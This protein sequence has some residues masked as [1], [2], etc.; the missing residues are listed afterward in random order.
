MDAHTRRCRIGGLLIALAAIGTAFASILLPSPVMKYTWIFPILLGFFAWSR[1]RRGKRLG[2]AA[3]A[4][5]LVL[6]WVQLDLAMR[7]GISAKYQGSADA[8]R[9]AIAGSLW[10]GALLWLIATVR[11]APV[12]LVID[13]NPLLRKRARLASTMAYLLALG[14]LVAAVAAGLAVPD[15]LARKSEFLL[16]VGGAGVFIAGLVWVAGLLREGRCA[17]DAAIVL[18]TASGLGGLAVFV[19]WPRVYLGESLLMGVLT[20]VFITI[21]TMAFMAG[22]RTIL[23]NLLGLLSP[24]PGNAGMTIEAARKKAEKPPPD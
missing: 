23:A 21:H 3:G 13:W 12:E 10:T 5:I 4:I 6:V 14:H 8:E 15:L 7:L 20:V 22:A 16:I 17:A 18:V 1:V 2:A 11:L 24:T 9:A 19:G